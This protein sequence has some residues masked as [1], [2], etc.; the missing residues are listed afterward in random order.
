MIKL[1][2]CLRRAPHLTREQFQ[3][4]WRNHHAAL[5]AERARSLGVVRY[6]QCHTLDDALARG[7]AESRN[8]PE[9]F[10][11]V[12]ELWWPSLEQRFGPQKDAA[13]RAGAE[14]LADEREFIDLAASP[15]F[16]VQEVEVVPTPSI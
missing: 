2:F 13:R 5:V 9:A 3:E 4:Y 12:A 14:L 7:L 1:M 8:A 15:I 6:V 16:Y 11:G 10:D